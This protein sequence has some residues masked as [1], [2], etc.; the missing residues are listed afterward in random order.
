M[1][2][3]MGLLSEVPTV[4]QT[5]DLGCSVSALLQCQEP[6]EVLHVFQPVTRDKKF[7]HRAVDE[8]VNVLPSAIRNMQ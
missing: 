5:V 8:G 4:T 1:K 6:W 2:A 7:S 3:L